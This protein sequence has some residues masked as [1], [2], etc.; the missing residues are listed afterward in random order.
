MMAFKEREKLQVC[1][2]LLHF[3]MQDKEILEKVVSEMAE[4]IIRNELP[5]NTLMDR[6]P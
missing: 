6:K 3:L 5:H 4:M 2:S 1:R